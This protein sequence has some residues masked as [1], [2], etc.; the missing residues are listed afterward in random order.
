MMGENPPNYAQFLGC[1]DSEASVAVDGGVLRITFSTGQ[2]L[3]LLSPPEFA[4]RFPGLGSLSAIAGPR[5]MGYRLQCG[6]LDGLG[7]S[8][9]AKG[10]PFHASRERLWLEPGVA[11][12]CVIEIVSA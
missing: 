6:A 3:N 12:G 4:K 11:E 10:V 5:F 8:L 7:R 9:G 1:L 2:C